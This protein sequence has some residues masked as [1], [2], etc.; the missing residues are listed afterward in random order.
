[1]ALFFIYIEQFFGITGHFYP[2]KIENYFIDVLK[3]I[4]LEGGAGV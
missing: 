2:L 1:M 3:K 4:F